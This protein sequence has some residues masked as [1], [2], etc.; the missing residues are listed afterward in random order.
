MGRYVVRPRSVCVLLTWMRRR[1]LAVPSS[2][3]A[4]GNPG[5]RAWYSNTNPRHAPVLTECSVAGRF[6]VGRNFGTQCLGRAALARW[7]RPSQETVRWAGHQAGSCRGSSRSAGWSI[8]RC[9]ARSGGAASTAAERSTAA[10][11]FYTLA[12]GHDGFGESR[13][14]RRRG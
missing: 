1:A 11:R 13:R 8:G 6:Q 2:A 7:T 14:G 4:Q 5:E 3:G 9:A 10:R 12:A